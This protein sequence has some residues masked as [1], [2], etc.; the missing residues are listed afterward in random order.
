MKRK[1]DSKQS[2]ANAEPGGSMY[3]KWGKGGGSH[4]VGQPGSSSDSLGPEEDL[5][6]EFPVISA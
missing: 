5:D 6:D 2:R 3:I 1:T 4:A